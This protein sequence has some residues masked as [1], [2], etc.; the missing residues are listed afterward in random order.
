MKLMLDKVLSRLLRESDI[1]VSYLS[2]VSSIPRTTLHGWVNGMKPSAK[3]IHYL[4][5][6]SSY[7][8]ISLN[9]LL[10]G[11]K[12]P[13]LSHTTVLFSGSFVDGDINYKIT[14]EKIVKKE[15]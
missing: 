2:Q 15:R 12:E 11:Q 5:M 13:H 8:Q 14:V 3:N 7:F 6:L 4:A 1:S 9:E 10:F